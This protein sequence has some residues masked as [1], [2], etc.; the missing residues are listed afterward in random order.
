MTLGAAQVRWFRLTRSGLVAPFATPELAA[1]ALGGVQSQILSA[2]GIALWNR[3]GGAL[4]ESDLDARLHDTRTLVKLWAQRGTLHLF[5]SSEWP[6]IHGA[7]ADRRS[8]WAR[9][10]AKYGSDEHERYE[11]IVAR[12]IALLEARGTLGRSDLRAADFEVPEWLLSSWGGIF[13]EL[14]GRGVACHAG[15]VG[16]EGRFAARTQWLPDLDWAPPP[17]ESANIELARRYL[18]TY[19]P[20]TAHDL[21]YWRGRG[22]GEARRWLGALGDEVVPVEVAGQA[23]LALRT[24]LSVLQAPPPPVE[25][26]PVRLLGRFDPLLLGHKAKGWLVAP[27]NYGQVWRPAGHIEGTLLLHGRIEGTWRYRRASRGLTITLVPFAPLPAA[28]HSAVAAEAE[29][30]ATFFALPLAGLEIASPG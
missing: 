8:W 6:L 17:A 30:L 15:Q 3:T 21:A 27:A 20:A 13:A 24:D 29:R 18:R 4:T 19:G 28:I 26:W 12:V 16:N 2:A 11:A 22:V 5:P 1:S 10:V 25:A 23:M 14:V 7:R 9:R